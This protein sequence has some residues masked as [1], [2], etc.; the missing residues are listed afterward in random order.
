MTARAPKRLAL[1]GRAFAF[2]APLRVASKAKIQTLP[3]EF[4]GQRSIRRRRGR[5]YGKINGRKVARARAQVLRTVYYAGT[6]E[7]ERLH[8]KAERWH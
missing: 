8:G 7:Q 6:R 5:M 1:V 2:H 4:I 3:K